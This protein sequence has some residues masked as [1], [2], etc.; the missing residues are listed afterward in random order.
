MKGITAFAAL[1]S[2]DERWITES[3]LPG[4]GDPVSVVGTDEPVPSPA[5]LRDRK[6]SLR[7]VFSSGRFAAALSLAVAL[8]VVVLIIRAG[9]MNPGVTPPV[10]STPSDTLLETSSDP[11]SDRFTYT[12]TLSGGTEGGNVFLQ[13]ERITITVRAACHGKAQDLPAELLSLAPD[14]RLVHAQ[15]GLILHVSLTSAAIPDGVTALGEG[16]VVTFTGDVTSP[17]DTAPAGRYDLLL[18]PADGAPEIMIGEALRLIAAGEREVPEKPYGFFSDQYPRFRLSYRAEQTVAAPGETLTITISLTNTSASFSYKG[19]LT[20]IFPSLL[21]RLGDKVIEGIGES[22][23][24]AP[25]WHSFPEGQTMTTRVT[26][27]IPEDAVS[28][29][30]DMEYAQ[31]H[32]RSYYDLVSYTYGT[33]PAFVSVRGEQTPTDP[34]ESGS[35]P[36][37]RDPAC[38]HLV[39][40]SWEET[41]SVRPGE[42]LLLTVTSD[43]TR[44]VI[45]YFTRLHG[46]EEGQFITGLCERKDHVDELLSRPSAEETPQTFCLIYYIPADTR[47]GTYDVEL[48]NVSDHMGNID[49]KKPLPPTVQVQVLEDPSGENMPATLLFPAFD[50]LF[51]WTDTTGLT[52]GT[53]A[54][55]PGELA[56]LSAQS[57]PTLQDRLRI[58]V[59]PQ[60]FDREITVL[61]GNAVAK[62][63][64]S[65][66]YIPKSITTIVPGA[67]K[68]TSPD[69]FYYQGTVEEW[70][71]AFHGNL[72]FSVVVCRDG[73]LQYTVENFKPVIYK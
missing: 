37:D 67:L 55:Y 62:Q 68:N 31:P 53:S 39:V 20:E 32:F 12:C 49:L 30:Y 41:Q 16:T 7:R 29:D 26:F 59:T 21:L 61:V 33:F 23:D 27:F 72:S 42:L 60:G 44:D 66:V 25:M 57:R 10:G 65:V 6:A 18:T 1:S 19:S 73:I 15:T 69:M 64:L 8:G 45:P 5:P 3:I 17:T 46:R 71:A 52:L 47:P 51:S 34:P 2:V 35:S 11:V 48:F 54:S 28:G 4:V 63:S 43:V 14:V 40:G 22:A 38:P 58:P 9:R 56:L 70:E 13:G 36:D 24:P 50:S